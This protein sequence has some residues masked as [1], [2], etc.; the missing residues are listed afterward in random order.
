[1]ALPLPVEVEV[2]VVDFREV[3]EVHVWLLG[4]IDACGAIDRVSG[5]LAAHHVGERQ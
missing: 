4:E 5:L 1:M 3:S 2:E